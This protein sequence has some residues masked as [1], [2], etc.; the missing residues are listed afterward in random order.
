[1]VLLVTI[2]VHMHLKLHNEN[3]LTFDLLNIRVQTRRTND[4]LR[5]CVKCLTELI[6]LPSDLLKTNYKI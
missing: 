1:M 3:K 2:T 4:E 6:M 5:N